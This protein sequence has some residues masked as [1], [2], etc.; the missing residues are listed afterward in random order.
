MREV[1]IGK[2]FSRGPVELRC[3]DKCYSVEFSSTPQCTSAC[4]AGV[5]VKAYV[6]L[7]ADKRYE[8]ALSVVLGSNPFPGICGRVCTHPCESECLLGEYS[9][10]IAIRSLKRFAADYEMSRR[11]LSAE[12][13][14]IVHREKIAV[15]GAGPAGLTAAS[16][17]S[18]EGYEVTVFER[19]PVPGGMLVLGIPRYRLPRRIVDFEIGAITLKGVHIELDS[20]IGN[21]QELFEKGYSA[22][23]IAAGAVKDRPL[24]IPGSHRTGVW[25]SISFL[26]RI[27]LGE[28]LTLEGRVVVVGGGSSAF[29]AARTA[30]RCGADE[31]TVVYRRTEN[32]MP[33]D[34]DEIKEAKDEGVK[35]VTLAV[36]KEILGDDE[37]EGMCFVKA[38]L[39]ELDDSG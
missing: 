12:K 10:P 39:G 2:L 33:A 18:D 8:D 20:E 29:D 27:N 19:A 7:I 5:N 14:K 35:I 11:H 9:H 25:G 31:V 4:P 1:D 13:N 6:N 21:A 23:I 16:D 28:S 17:L 26:E 36:P 3:A 22:V 32:E 37:V 34:R 15:I 24:H 38:R 30:V